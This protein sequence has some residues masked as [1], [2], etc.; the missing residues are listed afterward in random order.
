MDFVITIKF[1]KDNVFDLYLN[2]EWVASRS[3]YEN[4]LNETKKLIEDSLINK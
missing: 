4:I 1:A 2:G 3:H